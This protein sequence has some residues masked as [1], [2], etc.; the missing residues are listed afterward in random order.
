MY[1]EQKMAA[2][3]SGAAMNRAVLGAD[4]TR[5]VPAIGQAME[6]LSKAVSFLDEAACTLHA[7]VVPIRR[8]NP[9]AQSGANPTTP[10]NSPLCLSIINEAARVEALAEALMRTIDELEV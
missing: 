6:R 8:E 10:G 4:V 3:I 5:A 1:G 2:A 9:V 7:R